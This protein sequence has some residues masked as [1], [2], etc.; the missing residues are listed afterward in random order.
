MYKDDIHEY[1]YCVGPSRE[2]ESA[3]STVAVS[4]GWRRRGEEDIQVGDQRLLVESESTAVLLRTAPVL[5]NLILR[6]RWMRSGDPTAFIQ[7]ATIIL[8]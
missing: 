5:I 6:V 7:P 4:V 8:F 3:G 1:R 2:A